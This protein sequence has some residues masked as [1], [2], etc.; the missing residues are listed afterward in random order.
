VHGRLVPFLRGRERG[1]L[2]ASASDIHIQTFQEG[3]L[4]GLLAAYNLARPAGSAALDSDRFWAWFDDPD[5]APERDLWV[6]K[7]DGAVLGVLAALP[8]TSHLE[9][10]AI[11]LLGPSVLP[12]ARQR[13]VARAL[14]RAAAVACGQRH[15]GARFLSRV[16]QPAP[17]PMAFLDALGFRTERHQW[18]LRHDHLGHVPEPQ[19]PE[20]YTVRRFTADEDPAPL[21]GLYAAVLDQPERFSRVLQAEDLRRWHALGALPPGALQVVLQGGELVGLSLWTRWPGASEAELHVWGLLRDHRGLG[22]GRALLRHALRG[23]QAAGASTLRL[24][25]AAERFPSALEGLGF[26]LL[27]E[28]CFLACPLASLVSL[29]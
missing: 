7:A 24:S 18:V 8:W 6:A 3:D 10:G 1:G 19:W 20:G 2:V 27:E 9:E 11:F 12:A 21:E 5:L 13:G 16:P 4:P 25:V 23:A 28:E 29:P 22:L 15:P 14:V 26:V 17:G